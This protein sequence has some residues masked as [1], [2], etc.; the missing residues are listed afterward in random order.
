MRLG[1]DLP[2]AHAAPSGGQSFL[3]DLGSAR[4]LRVLV[5]QHRA[6]MHR[7]RRSPGVGDG[8]SA[9][10]LEPGGRL[11]DRRITR[12]SLDAGRIDEPDCI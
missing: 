6:S 5:H 9:S 8:E 4:E 1:F 12:N 11:Q 10:R 7:R 2:C 3:C